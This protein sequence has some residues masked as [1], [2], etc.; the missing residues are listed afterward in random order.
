MGNGI[1]LGL[2]SN[3]D[4]LELCLPSNRDYSCELPCSVLRT[5]FLT[6]PWKDLGRALWQRGLKLQVP[7]CTNFPASVREPLTHMGLPRSHDPSSPFVKSLPRLLQTGPARAGESVV[8]TI[9]CQE[10]IL[11]LL[12]HSAA[13]TIKTLIPMDPE[14]H[15]WELSLWRPFTTALSHT[16]GRCSVA[17]SVVENAWHQLC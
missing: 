15:L 8:K 12:G 3:C 9:H 5:P 6:A 2:A 11:V 14:T 7:M 4:L 1:L 16:L 10:S 13:R 17:L